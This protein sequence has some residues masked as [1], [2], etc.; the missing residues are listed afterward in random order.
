[1]SNWNQGQSWGQ[2]GGQNP[3]GWQYQQ[4]PGQ[5]QQQP[6]QFQQQPGQFQQQPGQFQQQPGQFQQQPG[7]FQQQPGQ[8][9]QWPGGSGG[10]IP[11]AKGG[12]SS[13]MILG[14]VGG[15]VALVV[16]IGVVL[17]LVTGKESPTPPPPVDPPSP[18][19]TEP[20]DP[21]DEPS[22]NDEPNPGDEPDPGDAGEVSVGGVSFDPAPGWEVKTNDGTV[23]MLMDPS[24]PAVQHVAVAVDGRSPENLL[25]SEMDNYLDNATNVQTGEVTT[26]TQGTQELAAMSGFG[27]VSTGDG[28][29]DVEVLGVVV[30]AEGGK[31]LITFIEAEEG[32][33]KSVLDSGDPDHVLN[34]I[35]PQL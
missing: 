29:V 4:Q 18:V 32:S 14:S 33:L 30:Q 7:Q 19:P 13:G 12:L 15:F 22:P 31:T 3:G 35:Y 8:Y 27:T 1:M 10:Q 28:T 2:Q 11:S 21:N 6:G 9:Q 26:E 20:A 16:I 34:Q 23:V 24:V 5:Y 17:M 25:R